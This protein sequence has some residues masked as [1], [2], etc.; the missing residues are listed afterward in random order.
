[1]NTIKIKSLPLIYLSNPTGYLL[2]SDSKC[3]SVILSALSYIMNSMLSLFE[4]ITHSSSL[5]LEVI[6]LTAIVNWIFYVSDSLKSFKI[7]LRY[8]LI[9]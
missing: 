6:K 7:S 4:C 3:S 5:S 8:G 1:M 9:L 2:R